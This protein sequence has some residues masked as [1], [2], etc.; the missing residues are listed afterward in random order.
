MGVRLTVNAE[1]IPGYRL[2]ERLGRGGYGEVWKA[3]APGGMLKAI[4]F[5]YGNLDEATENGKPA[6]QELKA[7]NRVKS[8]RHPYILSLERIDVIEG[9]LVIVME[10]ADR[11]LFDRFRECQLQGLP[12]IP[13][14]E[15]LRYMEETAEALDL[16]NTQFQLQHMDIKPQN[17]F[18]VFQHIKIA[19]FGLAKDLEGMNATLT[20]GVTPV[21]AAPE[22][23]ESRVTR[24]CDQYSLAI[25]YQ[26]LLTG[27]RPFHGTTARQLMMQH[28]QSPPDLV[29]LPPHDR[30]IIARALAK[31]PQQR[32]PSC[33]EMVRALRESERDN[34]AGSGK[35]PVSNSP[36][37][38]ATGNAPVEAINSP[39]LPPLV[40]KPTSPSHLSPEKKPTVANLR[41]PT[42]RRE[43]PRPVVPE[44]I[45]PGPLRPTLVIGL[46]QF[47]LLTLQ[48]L[49]RAVRERFGVGTLPHLRFLYLDTEPDTLQAISRSSAAVDPEEFY[50]ARLQRPSHYQQPRND[51]PPVTDWLP[52]S[53]LFRIPKQPATAGYRALGRLAFCDHYRPL[54]TRIRQEIEACTTESA[55]REA[56]AQTGLSFQTNYPRVYLV[57]SL[58]GGTGSGMFLDLA[59]AT[60]RMLDGMG[61]RMPDIHAL[62]YLP[63]VSE[64]NV[65]PLGLANAHAA[66]RELIHF[67]LPN[68]QYE[69]LFDRK[70]GLL[71]D[72]E[73]PFRRCALLPLPRLDDAQALRP[74]LGMAAGFLFQEI[75]TIV[76]READK[77]RGQ[78]THHAGALPL[79][80][81]GSYRL[82]W[83][84]RAIVDRLARE[85][86]QEI[87]AQWENRESAHL[88]QPLVAW[89]QQQL[90]AWNVEPTQLESLLDQSVA[91]KLGGDVRQVIE[92][93]LNPTGVPPEAVADDLHLLERYLEWVLQMV[94]PS[95]DGPGSE[96]GRLGE[97]LDEAARD[98]T[99]KILSQLSALVPLL[100]DQ[101]GWRLAGAEEVCRI[102]RDWLRSR[103]AQLDADGHQMA[104]PVR[105]TYVK[106]LTLIRDLESMSRGGRYQ[107]VAREAYRHLH[108]YIVQRYALLR[109]QAASGLLQTLASFGMDETRDLRTIRERIETLRNRIGRSKSTG[110]LSLFGPELPVLPDD[111]P[112][113]DAA[114]EALRAQVSPEVV[115]EL[116]LRLQQRL[117]RSHRNLFECFLETNND[118]REMAQM[119]LE[120]AREFFE[121]GMP[122]TTVADILLAHSTNAVVTWGD[123]LREAYQSAEPWIRGSGKELVVLT[124][125]DTEAGRQLAERVAKTLNRNDLCV[126]TGGADEVLFHREVQGLQIADLPLLGAAGQ[127]AFQESI[128]S[129]GVTPHSRTDVEWV[130]LQTMTTQVAF[131]GMP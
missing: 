56:S 36:P 8:I 99:S 69:A 2:I 13:R 22:T 94:G 9:Q 130:S 81:F 19:D 95:A 118:D 61:Y 37:A 24:F 5:V 42:P 86:C 115:T 125:P 4:K 124:V 32:F 47:G 122:E 103:A 116:E 92:S 18:L 40:R 70:D 73:P 63:E 91:Q 105:D 89:V 117:L 123:L 15:L 85:C 114:V 84:R 57:T 55:L 78:S 6:E 14:E 27:E 109:R 46:G 64:G 71:V 12:G 23:F 131:I 74:L 38:A 39:K 33:T 31:D 111:C 59:Y 108:A 45:G 119:M 26:E 60:K 25:V 120:E 11:N 93:T 67:S 121:R 112:D 102:V 110:Q 101:P 52:P 80:T 29:P 62:L 127:S 17:I 20:G 87:L 66:L 126:V 100:V 41:L 75:L 28:L 50:L 58:L 97:W 34:P 68:T 76:G 65:P 113:L 21:Y 10:L 90:P 106:V 51:L 72:P 128:E 98:L 30:P 44:K 107:A 49:R 77:G 54:L 35:P 82:T 53:L 3:E 48:R 16:M 83:P 88:V 96:R 129:S 1:P 79:Q 43:P 104:K 7:L